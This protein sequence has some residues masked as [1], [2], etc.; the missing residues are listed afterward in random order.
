MLTQ[1]DASIERQ[2]AAKCASEIVSA[3]MQA[4]KLAPEDICSVY[5][6]IYDCVFSCIHV[7][8]AA[9]APQQSTGKV[10]EKQIAL[11]R[12]LADDVGQETFGKLLAKQGVTKVSELTLK[13]ASDLITELKGVKDADPFKGE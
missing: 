10:T 6:S 8:Q 4:G 5:P 13:Q 12:R 1:K 7:E 2:C 11:L 9:P 3:M